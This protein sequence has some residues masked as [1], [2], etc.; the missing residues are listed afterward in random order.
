MA[1]RYRVRE[2]PDAWRA[3]FDAFRTARRK[4]A[5]LPSERNAR[6][7]EVLGQIGS[8]VLLIGFSAVHRRAGRFNSAGLP[9]GQARHRWPRGARSACDGRLAAVHLLQILILGGASAVFGALARRCAG[10]GRQWLGGRTLAA[11]RRLG[12]A[13]RPLA[14][15]ALFGV[16]IALLLPCRRLG[17]AL[18]VNPAALFRGVLGVVTHTPAS[19]HGG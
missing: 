18:T 8:G 15:A 5:H 12:D 7:G 11:Q 17:R 10:T 9:A 3:A 14:M 16:V 13:R 4:C 6:L 2:E 1:Y 19:A